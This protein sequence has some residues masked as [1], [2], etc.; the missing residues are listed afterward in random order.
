MN[1]KVEKFFEFL[2]KYMGGEIPPPKPIQID[3]DHA[4]FPLA[5]E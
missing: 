3:G 2:K 1:D 5:E 4:W